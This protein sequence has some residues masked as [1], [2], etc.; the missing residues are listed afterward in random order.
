M[1]HYDTYKTLYKYIQ[2][3]YIEISRQFG[4]SFAYL[5]GVSN[6][7]ASN[8]WKEGGVEMLMWP[9]YRFGWG[10]DPAM[11]MGRIHD[12]I[13][14][15]FSGYRG[16]GRFAAVNVWT[17]EEA[18]KV[19][20]ELPGVGPDDVNVQIEGTTLEIGGERKAPELGDGESYLQQDMNY[21]A[22]R[23]LVE[24]PYEV[25]PDKVRARCRDGVL[26]VE[27]PRSEA[28]KPKKIAVKTA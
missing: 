1:A 8:C 21:G 24:L 27:L 12:E 2:E 18:I 25:D 6:I 7:N 13:N 11:D 17:N 28:T 23:R 14:R 10:A 9:T 26:E 5:L 4:I 19:V 16:G 15:I 20:A 22:F 3:R